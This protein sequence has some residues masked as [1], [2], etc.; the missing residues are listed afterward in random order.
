MTAATLA[1][2]IIYTTPHGTLKV[3]GRQ[4]HSTDT[5]HEFL[6]AVTLA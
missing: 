5:K 1:G 3:T 6:V 4:P 2:S